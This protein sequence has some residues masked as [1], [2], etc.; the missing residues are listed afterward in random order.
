[1][2]PPP[3]WS[4][5]LSNVTVRALSIIVLQD[6]KNQTKPKTKQMH[7]YTHKKSPQKIKPA[8]KTQHLQTVM[9]E[10]SQNLIMSINI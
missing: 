7:T 10:D 4:G 6:F 9:Q 8:H 5:E 1:M 2:I 3:F